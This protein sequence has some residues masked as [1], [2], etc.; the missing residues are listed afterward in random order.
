MSCDSE[1]GEATKLAPIDLAMLPGKFI[2]G[3]L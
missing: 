1:A 3:H 2:Y